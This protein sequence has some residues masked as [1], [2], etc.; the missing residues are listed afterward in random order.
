MRSAIRAKLETAVLVTAVLVLTA[1]TIR[2]YAEQGG[3]FFE[4]PPT[5]VEHVGRLAHPSRDAVLLLPKVARFLPRGAEVACF[6][7]V[8]GAPADDSP[9]YL[10]A[11]GMLP[12]QKVLPSFTA[13]TDLP[14]DQ[15]VEYV[16]AV[17][18]PFLH[19]YYV[20]VVSFPEG[21]LYRVSR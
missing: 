1:A 7:P 8:A 13:S 12:H 15:L 9:N 21:T 19:P 16:V 20:P 5:F 14:R 2:H 4:V 18:D 10:T 6:K 3:P 17:R 11:V